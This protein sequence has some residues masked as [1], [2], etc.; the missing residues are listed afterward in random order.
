MQIR[1]PATEEGGYVAKC[2]G[3][4]SSS[5]IAAAGAG[6]GAFVIKPQEQSKRDSKNCNQSAL[7]GPGP[8][9]SASERAVRSLYTHIALI[10]FATQ[11]NFSEW[12]TNMRRTQS[13][14]N[15]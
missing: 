3:G 10:S 15:Q 7:S 14:F 12:L 4:S 5:S 6:A 9:L 1:G 8:I 13:L 11:R 2:G